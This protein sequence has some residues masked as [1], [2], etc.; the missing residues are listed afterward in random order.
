MGSIL[1]L[2][3]EVIIVDE[4]T[5]GQDWKDSLYVCELL[6]S[7]NAKGKTIVIITHEMDLVA[8]FATRVIVMYKGRVL[9]DG[10]PK[11][12]FSKPEVLEETWVKPP[13]VTTLF[14]TLNSSLPQDIITVEEA[15]E[16]LKEVIR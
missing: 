10:T 2:D 11:E 13:Q 7:L 6:R 5:T 16:Y 15:Y 4:P 1:A 14:Q 3:P 8:E 9:L 12:V